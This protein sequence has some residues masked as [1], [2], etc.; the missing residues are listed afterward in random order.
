MSRD[1]PVSKRTLNT[2]RCATHIPL[3]DLPAQDQVQIKTFK[4]FLKEVAQPHGK[5]IIMDHRWVL[6]ADGGPEPPLFW[7]GD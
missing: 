6:Y 2:M 7:E 4:R 3:E 5:V 1:V